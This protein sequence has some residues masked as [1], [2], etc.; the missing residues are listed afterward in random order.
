MEVWPIEGSIDWFLSMVVIQ[1]DEWATTGL[2]NRCD[3]SA[4]SRLRTGV[5]RQR[6]GVVDY[7][8]FVIYKQAWKS[9]SHVFRIYII[10]Y[11]N[12]TMCGDVP[13]NGWVTFLNGKVAYCNFVGK[14]AGSQ[15][16]GEKQT[17]LQLGPNF[18]V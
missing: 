9:G 8:E 5:P 6:G 18:V 10:L 14:K 13:P 2:L 11:I 3:D 7:D 4:P 16:E 17:N 1:F 12:W 15:L